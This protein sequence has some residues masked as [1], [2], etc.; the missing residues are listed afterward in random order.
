MGKGEAVGEPWRPDHHLR[1]TQ[2]RARPPPIA[3][4]YHEQRLNRYV[5]Q[6]A[7]EI[8]FGDHGRTSGLDAPPMARTS[9]LDVRPWGERPALTF[10]P[11]VERLART[12][13]HG[14]QKNSGLLVCGWWRR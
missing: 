4:S 11:W 5:H 9:G 1:F 6:T 8:F 13:A 14:L 10:G 7:T 3:Y 2:I 12:S